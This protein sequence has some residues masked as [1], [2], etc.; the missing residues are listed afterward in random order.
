LLI[1]GALLGPLQA[2]A[3]CDDCSEFDSVVS[4]GTVTASAITEASGL[5]ASRVNS[6]VLWTHND[7]SKQRVFAVSTNGALLASFNL[8]VEVFDIEDV[9]V[10]PGTTSRIPCVYFGDIGGNSF[11]NERRTEVQL[12]RAPEP[13]INLAWASDPKSGVLEG[14][15]VFHL[16]YPDGSYEAEALL[17]DPKS[18]QVYIATKQDGSS[19]LYRADLST[20]TNGST[21]TLTFVRTI[22]FDSVSAA[23]ISADGSRIILRRE[24]YAAAWYRCEGETISQA[25]ARSGTAIPLPGTVLEPNGEAIAYLPDGSG[26]LTLGEGISPQLF[27]FRSKCPRAPT[28]TLELTS[29]AGYEG[30][31]VQFTGVASGLPQPAYYWTFNG[32]AITGATSNTLTISPLK[33]SHAGTYVLVATNLSGTNTSAAQLMVSSLPNLRITEVQSS[34]AP[35][36]NLPTSDWWELTNFEDQP[37]DISGWRF[38]DVSGDL[39]DAF[40]IPSGVV[41]HPGESVIFAE[42]LTQAQ[43]LTWWGTN[44]SSRTQIINYSGSGL[45]LAASGDAVRLW[46]S[47]AT[48]ASLVAARVDFGA[49]VNGVTFNFD[50]TTMTFGQKSVVGVNGVFKA[51]AATDIGSPGRV[52]AP[53]NA[54]VLHPSFNGFAIQIH[55]EATLGSRYRLER[56]TDNGNTWSLT[57]DV[58]YGSA[59]ATREFVDDASWS[60]QLYR[61][62]VD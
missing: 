57:G 2:G 16:R 32:T 58:I 62:V 48:S 61:V 11:S 15:E 34:T 8:G 37:V 14:M 29:L 24:D 7:G 53:P 56:S 22:V 51:G 28:F 12:L 25:F 46:T 59:T 5:A 20:A 60:S 33:A 10:A 21:L 40:V 35:S 49:A 55:F 19:R 26:Y 27:Y 47:S 1:A 43:F 54:P 52:V 18:E 31:T 41:L 4:W 3:Q 36:P 45:S 38:N 42:E 50:P 9:A 23:D 44:V 39:T 17:V 30:G 6:G 13:T